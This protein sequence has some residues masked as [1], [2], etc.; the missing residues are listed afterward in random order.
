MALNFG[1]LPGILISPTA[2]LGKLK[3]GANLA[4]GLTLYLAVAAIAIVINV[5]VSLITLSSV[6]YAGKSLMSWVGGSGIASIMLGQVFSLV[7]GLVIFLAICLLTTKITASI[8][9]KKDDLQKTTGLLSYTGAAFYLF[10]QLPLSVIINVV[11]FG[12][13]GQTMAQSMVTGQ[14]D[15]AK[16]GPLAGVGLIYLAL[17][18]AMALWEWLIAGKAA[19]IANGTTW[20]AGIAGLLLT[21]IILV[22]VLFVIGVTIGV[23]IGLGSISSVSMTSTASPS[24]FAIAGL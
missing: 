8:G 20:G 16:A 19:G 11:M 12:L 13:M 1:A 22:V 17:L 10:I 2:T 6:T 23:A 5:V 3:K 7:I 14:I 15:P 24:G 21:M 9:G 18:L 4:D